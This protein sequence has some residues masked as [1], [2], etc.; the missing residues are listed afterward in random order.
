MMM[1]MIWAVCVIVPNFMAIGR[2]V[3]EVWWFNGFRNVDRPPSWIFKIS[4]F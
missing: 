2:T 1:M 4:K 3:V